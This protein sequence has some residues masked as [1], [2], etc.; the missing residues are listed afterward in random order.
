MQRPAGVNIKQTDLRRPKRPSE[1]G[2]IRSWRRRTL[3]PGLPGS[4][5]RAAGLNGRVREGNGC[6]PHAMA[7][8][9]ISAPSGAKAPLDKNLGPGSGERNQRSHPFEESSSSITT[10]LCAP[11]ARN[12]MRF[13]RYPRQSSRPNINEISMRAG[14]CKLKTS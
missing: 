3:P 7:T 13:D 1:V 14:R 12:N 11:T 2:Q 8:S 5:I 9:T 6:I 4:T 10:G